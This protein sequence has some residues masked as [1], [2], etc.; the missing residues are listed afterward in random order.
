MPAMNGVAV[1]TTSRPSTNESAARQQPHRGR[2]G[3]RKAPAREQRQDDERDRRRGEP[4]R[5][6]SARAR[7]RR[8][9]R[10]RAR[11][12]A[13][14]ARSGRRTRTSA[15]AMRALLTRRTYSARPAGAS[16]LSRRWNRRLVRARMRPPDDVRSAAAGLAS[17]AW[18]PLRKDVSWK[19]PPTGPSGPPASSPSSL[20]ALAVS[21]LAYLR[22][23][24]V[25]GPVS[26]P[27]G[28]ARRPADPEA[29]H[30]RHR[31]RRLP[32]RLRHAGGAREPRRAALAPDRAAGDPHP[33][34]L[35]ASRHADLP[36]RG[37]AGPHEHAL[38]EGEPVRR[39]PR[40]R[41]RR[42][43]RRRRLVAA[44]LPR[45]RVGAEALGRL[46]R[47][48]VH[49]R[50]TPT[51]SARARTACRPTAS[52]SPATR[53]PARRRPRGRPAR[54][55]L[56]PHRPVS[57]SAGTRTAMIYG[58]RHPRS[59][60]R[61]VMI[62]VN[63]PGHFV[64]DPQGHRRADP[65]LLRR[66]ARRTTAAAGAR[67]IWPHRCG[68][69]PPTSPTAGVPADQA[70]QRAARLVLRPHGHDV[71][72]GADLVADDDRLVALGRARRRERA[73]VHVADGR[74]RLPRVVRVGRAGRHGDP[75]APT[76][77]AYYSA[78]GDRGSILGNPERSSSGP[79]E[80]LADA[81][82]RNP[83]DDQ[84]SRVRTSNVETLLIGG[85]LDFATPPQAATRGAAAAPAR[86][87]TRSCC[88]SSA[89]RRTSG[90][91]SPTAST[92]PGQHV[93]RQRA[94]RRLAVRAAGRWTS[95]PGRDADGARQGHRRRDGRL[96]AAR[97]PVAAADVAPGAQPRALRAQGE[98]RAALRLS[99]VLGLGGWFLGA[100]IVMT[101]MPTVPL[102]SERA[103][104]PRRSACRSGSASTW[105]GCI[106]TGRARPRRRI[107]RGGRRGARG[108]VAGI[109]RHRPECS[110]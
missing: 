25:A 110:R 82:P 17:S 77:E 50:R 32:R 89:T 10:P 47:R 109:Q 70:G 5:R 14:R 71:R 53:C 1:N 44:R 60:Q 55:R 56:P 66:C 9:A 81:W 61:S 79:A 31:A 48:E 52:T 3:E 93:P 57:E 90:R 86:T 22:F 20:I 30:L 105:H 59:I 98:R 42:L 18:I 58:W 74:P 2:R 63:P 37:R 36:A 100:L 45:G 38:L 106:A 78:G 8:E 84:Y 69:P 4:A 43:P 26:V 29:V 73:L 15:R 95:T 33:G 34:S 51:P 46:P 99:V 85:T 88:R 13:P 16:Y 67:T 108:R 41:A 87:A 27:S 80:R 97:A 39:R 24:P 62:G 12:R 91:T 54:A 102:D 35:G 40:R 7:G 96:R 11:S 64:W 23:A 92:P 75:D 28:R 6:S 21:A 68:A 104:R 65:P 101:T 49:A 19:P 83:A 72:G 76:A 107:R 103:R 94:G